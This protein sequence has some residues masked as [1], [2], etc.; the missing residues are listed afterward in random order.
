MTKRLGLLLALLLLPRGAHATIW[1]AQCQTLC[2][3]TGTVAQ[4]TVANVTGAGGYSTGFGG[5]AVRLRIT[6]EHPI[7][8]VA[9][10]LTCVPQ[11]DLDPTDVDNTVKLANYCA[12][13]FSNTGGTATSEFWGGS[14][15]Q[16]TKSGFT[17]T[18]TSDGSTPVYPTYFI[19]GANNFA[20]LGAGNVVAAT[21]AAGM[22]V[23]YTFLNSASG[24]GASDDLIR[25]QNG[26]PCQTSACSADFRA[27]MLYTWNDILAT[28]PG[29]VALGD[30]T[31]GN[32]ETGSNQ[33]TIG[34]A[35]ALVSGGSGYSAATTVSLT[36]GGGS[37]F[38]GIVLASAGGVTAVNVADGGSGYVNPPTVVF[39]G[40]CTASATA[41]LNL[42]SSAIRS[43]NVTAAGAGCSQ[44]SQLTLNNGAN[45]NVTGVSG[46][47]ITTWQYGD[48]P[49]IA[50]YG[51]GAVV[52][53]AT[54]GG[55][56]GATWT[57]QLSN[58]GDYSGNEVHLAYDVTEYQQKLVNAVIA[59]HSVGMKVGDS[60]IQGTFVYLSYWND[61]FFGPQGLVSPSYLGSCGS[62]ACQQHVGGLT[63]TYFSKN[64][65]AIDYAGNLP[66]S[67]NVGTPPQDAPKYGLSNNQ[68]LIIQ[69]FH[70]LV[71]AEA[72]A[73][74]DFQNF[75]WYQTVPFS[76]SVAIA[77]LASIN[78]GLPLAMDEVGE[79]GNSYIDAV[80][81]AGGCQQMGSF[82]CIWWNRNSG[83]NQ[84]A[85]VLQFQDGTLNQNGQAWA[86]VISGATIPGTMQPAAIETPIC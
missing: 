67:C 82:L 37:G 19:P 41:V 34:G 7:T 20:T 4:N 3:G 13:S 10:G 80:N 65:N 73:H 53:T 81:I 42:V 50:I 30:W 77:W 79:Y 14:T 83:F 64:A 17:L 25:D 61:Q 68:I 46:G 33:V 70:S 55:G 69:K 78:G 31:I 57:F 1:G 86:D 60:G 71:G 40:G 6:V 15:V 18:I 39:S 49:T 52:P 74:T 32:E 16:Y 56:T 23:D 63:Q 21:Q 59:G 44:G 5:T 8:D 38:K 72:V 28:A 51:A 11:A 26:L 27:N 85:I 54:T 45:I 58:N 66:N 35:T 43:I 75:H 12:S 62:L 22:Y 76:T 29:R 36:G 84:R 2:I 48:Y 47:A 24:G 9:S